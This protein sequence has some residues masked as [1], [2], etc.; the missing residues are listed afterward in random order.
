MAERIQ[1]D[2][3]PAK[4]GPDAHEELDRLLNS[5]HEHGVLRFAN[6]LVSANTKVTEVLVSGLG[7]PGTLNAIQNLSI[8]GMALSR[9]QPNDFYKVIFAATDSVNALAANG[10]PKTDAEA[11]GVRGTYKML[12]DDQLWQGVMPLLEAIK[13]FAAGLEREVDKPITSFTGKPGQQ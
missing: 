1:Y 10:A 3:K 5:L 11:P 7:K 8:L 13:V 9:I 2:P 6:D 12:Q 4:I